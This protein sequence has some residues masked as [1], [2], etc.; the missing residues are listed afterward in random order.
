MY[1]SLVPMI[2]STEYWAFYCQSCLLPDFSDHRFAEQLIPFHMSTRESSSGITI[3]HFIQS[4]HIPFSI[5]NHAHIHKAHFLCP[6]PWCFIQWF[7]DSFIYIWTFWSVVLKYFTIWNPNFRC[8]YFFTNRIH[9]FFQMLFIRKNIFFCIIVS[10]C[11]KHPVRNLF[12][13]LQFKLRIFL[14]CLQ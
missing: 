14:V 11:L 5:Q 8:Y 3:I 6:A 4:Q 13:L 12:F 1:C 9:H 2:Q 10:G 7:S